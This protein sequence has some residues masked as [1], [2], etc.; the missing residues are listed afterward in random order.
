MRNNFNEKTWLSPYFDNVPKHVLE[1]ARL[2]GNELHKQTEVYL[3]HAFPDSRN[4]AR[5]EVTVASDYVAGTIDA[6]FMTK[7]IIYVSLI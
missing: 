4:T 5:F 3:N 7:I 2:R 6:M 1:S